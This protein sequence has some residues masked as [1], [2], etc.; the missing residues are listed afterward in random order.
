LPN[1]V[2]YFGW[3]HPKTKHASRCEIDLSLGTSSNKIMRNHEPLSNMVKCSGFFFS[4][5][6]EVAK[7]SGNHLDKRLAKIGYKPTYESQG[8]KEE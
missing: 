6:L 5:I 2:T 3:P 4:S 1:G 7:Q 8:K